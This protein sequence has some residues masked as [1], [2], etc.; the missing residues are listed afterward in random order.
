MPGVMANPGCNELFKSAPELAPACCE[1]LPNRRKS[2]MLMKIISSRKLRFLRPG[3]IVI[4]RF[5]PLQ[6]KNQRNRMV[7]LFER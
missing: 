4:N 3:A 5:S 2:R 7:T 1:R 6:V